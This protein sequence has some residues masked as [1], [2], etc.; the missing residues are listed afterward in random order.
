M[1]VF[2][3]SFFSTRFLWLLVNICL[4]FSQRYVQLIA[5]NWNSG[6]SS[7]DGGAATSA[8]IAYSNGL[9]GDST[10]NL[11]VSDQNGYR[12]RLINTN[13]IISTLAGSGVQSSAGLSASFASVQF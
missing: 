12:V 3:L 6:P 11:Y 5:G 1:N 9:W 2:R 4:A 10:G 13:G 7:G 8:S